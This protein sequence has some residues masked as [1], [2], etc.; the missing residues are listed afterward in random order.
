MLLTVLA[1]RS[2]RGLSLPQVLCL[3]EDRERGHNHIAAAV[4]ALRR[5]AFLLV[6]TQLRGREGRS[7]RG[8]GDASVGDRPLGNPL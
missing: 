4:V 7:C 1:T 6:S 3:L 5:S 8:Y 2:R